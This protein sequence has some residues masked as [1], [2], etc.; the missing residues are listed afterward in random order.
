MW[1]CLVW[2]DV[3][4]SYVKGAWCGCRCG[5]ELCEE[6]ARRAYDDIGIPISIIYYVLKKTVKF[7]V[8]GGAWCGVCV[9]VWRLLK[10]LVCSC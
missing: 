1:R 5:E 6:I 10:R 4:R 8:W 3:G 7:G 2:V 9:G